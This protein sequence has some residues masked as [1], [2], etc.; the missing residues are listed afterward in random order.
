MPAGPSCAP[1]TRLDTGGG[2]KGKKKFGG[3]G[4]RQVGYRVRSAWLPLDGSLDL[5]ASMAVAMAPPPPS[6]P[7]T[8]E[9]LND[10]AATIL[11]TEIVWGRA[12]AHPGRPHPPVERRLASLGDRVLYDPLAKGLANDALSVVGSVERQVEVAAAVQW[13]DLW[14]EPDPD[15]AAARG[16]LGLLGE[17][18]AE[19]CQLEPFARTPDLRRIRACIR[20]QLH[21]HHE[22]ERLARQELPLGRLCIT[23]PGRPEAA[24]TE[25]GFKERSPGV[26]QSAP[27][28]RIYVLVLSE[29]PRNRETILLRLLGSGRIL[30]DAITELLALE[31]DAWEKELAIPW[32]VRLGIK[33]SGLGEREEEAIMSEVREWFERCK[34]RCVHKGLKWGLHRGKRV[35][36]R[37]G[38]WEGKRETLVKLCALRLGRELSDREVATLSE[39][40]QQLGDRGLGEVL[41]WSSPEALAA[42]LSGGEQ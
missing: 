27:G 28:L 23:S 4:H 38:K 20:K 17:V 41:L 10:S 22:R 40:L 5:A 11:G 26:Y 13:M 12:M 21:W 1:F 7:S 37:V 2:R 31:D 6:A 30:A 36:K 32:L 14:H 42:W 29:V 3:S 39:R 15:R 33:H 16:V 24:L 19:P 35:G 34:Q 8:A 18:T 9:I 25:L